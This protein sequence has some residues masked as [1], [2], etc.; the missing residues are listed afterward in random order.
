LADDAKGIPPEVIKN[1]FLVDN[2]LSGAPNVEAAL[3]LQ[4]ELLKAMQL[5]S[6]QLLKYTSN[7][8]QVL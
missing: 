8:P 1:D 5:G 6:H 4:R 3:T 7:S 2:L